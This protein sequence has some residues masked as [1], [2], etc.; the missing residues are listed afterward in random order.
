MDQATYN[1]SALSRKTLVDLGVT[2]A[3]AVAPLIYIR[4][5]FAIVHNSPHGRGN[6]GPT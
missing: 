2:V 4:E 3:L 6:A 1:R 5:C